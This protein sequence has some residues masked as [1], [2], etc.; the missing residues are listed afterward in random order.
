MQQRGSGRLVYLGSG[1]AKLPTVPTLISAGVAKAGIGT[2][3]KYLAKEAGPAGITANVVSPGMVDTDWLQASPA[4]AR[5]A[6][7]AA[8]TPLRRIAQPEDIARAIAFLA[9]D[10]SGFVT[11]TTMYVNGGVL[12]D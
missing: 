12:M 4:Q 11:G 10:E 3:V 8:M 9:S 7:M 5:Q 6:A 2:L 1:A